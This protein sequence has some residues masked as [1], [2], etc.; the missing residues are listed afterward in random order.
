[1]VFSPTDDYIVS[2]NMQRLFEDLLHKYNVDLA[3]W[4]HYHSYERTCKVYRNRC[5]EDGI[6]N[7]V[8]GTAGRFLDLELFMHKDWSVTRLKEYGY[9]RVTV[10]NHTTMHFEFIRNKDKVVRDSFYL[11][12]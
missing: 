8:I 3:L 1:M 11:H 9:G 4:A 2:V 6:T 7:V 12:R 10:F 5:A